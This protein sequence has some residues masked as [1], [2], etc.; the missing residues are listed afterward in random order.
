MKHKLVSTFPTHSSFFFPSQ[1]DEHRWVVLFLAAALISKP[2][3]IASWWLEFNWQKPR[4]FGH[5]KF[6]HKFMD[7]Q[8]RYL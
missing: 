6:L 4:L 1:P 7:H 2:A 8:T 5:E 3:S